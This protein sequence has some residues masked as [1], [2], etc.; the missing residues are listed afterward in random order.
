ML[1]HNLTRW[2][3]QLGD[4]LD[5]GHQLLVTKTFRTRLL[6]IPGRL[7]NHS[8]KPTLR[9]PARWPWAQRYKTALAA[10]RALP[11]VPG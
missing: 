3:A 9:M 2:T 1:A 6:A 11:P 5:P 10:L 7:A 4:T 8:G